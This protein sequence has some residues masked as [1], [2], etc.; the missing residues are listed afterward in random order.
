MW[1][2]DDASSRYEDSLDD[3]EELQTSKGYLNIAGHYATGA[4]R[5]NPLN[6]KSRPYLQWIVSKS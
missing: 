2:L 4:L 3:S 6:L 1:A 5:Q